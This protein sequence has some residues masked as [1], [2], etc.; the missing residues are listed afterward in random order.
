MGLD[1]SVSDGQAVF[2]VQGFAQ[3]YPDIRMEQLIN[4]I[5]CR[6]DTSRSDAK[7]VGSRSLLGAVRFLMESSPVTFMATAPRHSHLYSFAMSIVFVMRADNPETYLPTHPNLGVYCNLCVCIYWGWGGGYIA[8]PVSVFTWGGGV[9]CNSYIC[10]YWGVGWGLYCN[11]CVCIYLGGGGGGYI[12]SSTSVFT[13]GGDILQPMCLY[14]P[15]HLLQLQCLYLPGAGGG[16]GCILQPV[17]LHDYLVC[18]PWSCLTSRVSLCVLWQIQS[19]N[20]MT[21]TLWWSWASVQASVACVCVFQ[22]IK[23]L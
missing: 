5:L 18:S 12:A 17:C 21:N 4:L 22:L 8:T 15:G 16:G 7:Q 14:L 11:S 6:G 10:I 1:C 13:V 20:F 2:V 19:Y 3:K 9:Y 23:T